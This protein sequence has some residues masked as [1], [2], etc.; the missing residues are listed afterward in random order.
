MTRSITPRIHDIGGFEVGR[1]LPAI[2]ARSVGP[3][4]FLDRMGPGRF[5]AGRG[6][7]V[8]PHPHIGLATL[9]YLFDGV[10]THRDSLGSVQDILP[11]D[12]NWMVAGRGI[13]HSERTPAATR[14]AAHTLDGLQ[15]WLA[16]PQPDEEIA[17][18]FFHYPK[19]A[20]P[21]IE[22]DG[23]AIT[24]VAGHGFGRCAPVAVRSGTL[25]A[26]LRVT[27]GSRLTLPDEHAQRAIYPLDAG[28][29]LDGDP[30]AVDQLH[31]LDEGTE[32]GLAAADGGRCVLLGGEPLDG[33]RHLWWNFVSSRS[34]RIEQARD[35]WRQR[36]FP[37]VPGDDE[38]IPLPD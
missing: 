12:V 1:L 17:P 26:D 38:R 6:V 27:A 13:V 15:C 37:E 16:L 34:E 9:T 10:I 21:L 24:I 28:F 23:A 20:L 29:A 36:R 7:D 35:D 4:V 30:L 8:R 18:A 22:R 2:S 11:G 25:F 33:P 19:S 3:F 14:E 5:E 32:P 31:L